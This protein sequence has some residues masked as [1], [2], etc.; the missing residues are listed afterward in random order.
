MMSEAD[1]IAGMFAVRTAEAAMAADPDPA[2]CAEVAR[3]NAEKARAD[4]AVSALRAYI[5]CCG[6]VL[7]TRDQQKIHPS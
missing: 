4:R 2:G 7:T 6:N 1:K 3:A 5:E